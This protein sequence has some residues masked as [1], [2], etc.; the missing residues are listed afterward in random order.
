[1]H[2]S[3]VPFQQQS[4]EMFLNLDEL[5]RDLYRRAQ[6]S[7]NDLKKWEKRGHQSGKR[8]R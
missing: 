5:E 1:M 2:A 8:K 3:N 7:A 6:K 4:P